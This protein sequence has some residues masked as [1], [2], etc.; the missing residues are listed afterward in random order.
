MSP[1]TA[2]RLAAADASVTVASNAPAVTDWCRRYFGPWWN[3]APTTP[4][5]P[6]DAEPVRADVDPD[7]YADLACAVTSGDHREVSYAR[8]PA[9]L[10]APTPAG[11][12]TAV[13]PQRRLAYQREPATGS[14]TILGDEPEQVAMA[15]A[16]IAR[17][18]VRGALLGSG[19]T[20]VHASAAAGKDGRTVLAFG[21]KGAGKT[22]VAVL[23]AAAGWSLLAND[24]AFTRADPDGGLRLL[25]WPAAAAVGLGLMNALGWSTIARQRLQAGQRLHPT[26][27]QRVTDALLSARAEPLREPGSGR[28]LKAQVWPEQFDSWFGL[29]LATTGRAAAALFPRIAPAT[30]PHASSITRALRDSDFMTGATEDR[31][32]DIFGLTQGGAGS[33]EARDQTTRRL[34]ELP[35]HSVILGHDTAANT[36]LL[37][38]RLKDLT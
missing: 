6:G 14:F 34:A 7:A 5:C 4:H 33:P 25:P 32:P 28:E 35:G 21:S 27:D 38:T 3:A 8:A 17:D 9:L 22:T 15:A 24:R 20:L 23:L 36:Q 29:R 12:I 10:A 13:C 16:R 37:T 11:A 30:T 26:Q 31:Y 2:T 18:T 19:W 1:L